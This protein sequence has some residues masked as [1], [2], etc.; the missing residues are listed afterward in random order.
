[1]VILAG[2][3]GGTKCNLA[4]YR[5]KSG[6]LEPFLERRFES[7]QYAGFHVIVTE[8]LQLAASQCSPD[9][10]AVAGFGVAGPVVENRVKVTNLP[11]VLDGE[12]LAE[13]TGLRRVVLLNDFAATANSLDHLS[14]EDFCVLNKGEVAPGGA[15]ALIGAGTGLGQ[16][17]LF[18]DGAKYRVAGAE[19][20]HADFSPH[21]EKQLDLLR[22]ILKK[23]L[24]PSAKTILSGHGILLVHEF[25]DPAAHHP[26]FDVPGADPAPEISRCGLDGSCPVCVETLDFWT[27]I[28]GSET[29]NLALRGLATG[30]V[31][32]AGGIA[33]KILPKMADGRFL[34]AFRDKS[35][36][37][38]LLGR[39]PLSIVLNEKA[40]LIGAG[41]QA[42]DESRS[43][44]RAG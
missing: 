2:D 34:R 30:G 6:Q 21:D 16:V 36:M 42:L 17:N 20:G 11:W 4:L 12:A 7:K 15:M 33:P 25:L 8:F 22:F 31:Y 10:I 9:R 38:D 37:E 18:W 39:V 13:K 23:S 43:L 1:M 32:V 3:I 35:K 44:A 5:E 19:A 26:I 24:P 27:K 28:Y 29:G 41:Y 40:P 14:A